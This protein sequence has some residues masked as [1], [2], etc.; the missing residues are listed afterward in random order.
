MSTRIL[1]SAGE[2]SGENYGAELIAS[3]CRVA[4][5]EQFEFFGLGGDR[6]R[7]AGCDLVIHSKDVAVVGLVEVV[8]HL[9]RIYRE[10]HKLLAEVDKHKPDAAVLI[11]F[12]D[13]NFRL[14]RKLRQRG[15]PVIYYVSP[16]L[17]AWRKSR[18]KLVQRFVDKM[19]V[20]FPFEAEFYRQHSVDA[21]YVGHPLA[22]MPPLHLDRKAYAEEFALDPA[23]T[24]I[25]LLPGSRI[26][27]IER[28]LETMQNAADRF[29]CDYEFI[30]PIAST[31][32]ENWLEAES[33]K[34]PSENEANITFVSDARI[35][36]AHARA[37]I[38]A[39]GTATVEA[40]LVGN[41]FVVV[42]RVAPLTFALGRRLVYLPNYAMVNLIA[43][44][45]IVP[46]LIQNDFTAENI[47]NHLRPLLADG[48]ERAQMVKD[49]TEV[50]QKL[51]PVDDATASD[52]AAQAVLKV[53]RL[54]STA[55]RI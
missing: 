12:P 5:L 48:P 13:F 8:R 17:W 31:I 11:D 39:S 24:W 14:A 7:A 1:I 2:A 27:E 32:D 40:A 51:N 3:L 9:P 26:G 35:A 50:R 33:S 22:D 25:A 42:Y 34:Y 53:V 45:T 18:I 36:L 49:L 21:E 54:K 52:R 6:M 43:G 30:L 37:A 28:N 20:I 19:L 16:Q 46:E 41:P 38:V 55:A 29:G 4:P 23:K 10:F 15:I 44:H 47:V